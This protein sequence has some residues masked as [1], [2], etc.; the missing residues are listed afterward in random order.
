MNTRQIK[1]VA[2]RDACPQSSLPRPGQS[3]LWTWHS[4]PPL[5]LAL[6]HPFRTLLSPVSASPSS[7]SE[8][9]AVRSLWLALLPLDTSLG[10]PSTV[11]N[12]GPTL[13]AF[14]KP[15]HPHHHTRRITH[16]VHPRA[17]PPSGTT[18]P[19]VS[20]SLDLYPYITRVSAPF[21]NHFTLSLISSRS[22][23]QRVPH[24]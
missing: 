1:C 6:V 17:I 5:P 22:A 18:V 13:P 3:S 14:S 7:T 20:S 11:K 9:H 24:V 19:S 8:L 16:H 2:R 12:P 10:N 4:Q 15:H 23:K 21:I